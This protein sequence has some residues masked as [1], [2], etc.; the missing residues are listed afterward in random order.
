[1][2]VLQWTYRLRLCWCCSGT[3]SC[4]GVAGEL[5]VVLVSVLQELL[6]VSVSVWQWS[7]QLCRCWCCSRT[8]S[9]VGVGVAVELPV[10]LV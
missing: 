5:A 8:T 9:S 7:Y 4:I 6:V 3:N 1:V 2:L 10:F